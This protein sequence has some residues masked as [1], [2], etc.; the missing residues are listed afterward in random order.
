MNNT[1]CLTSGGHAA[2]AKQHFS[3]KPLRPRFRSGRISASP[4]LILFGVLVAVLS[5]ALARV[6][7]Q[8]AE[9]AGFSILEDNAGRID[10]FVIQIAEGE[11]VRLLPTI[12]DLLTQV[13][14]RTEGFL[15]CAA[16]DEANEL[17]MALNRWNLAQPDRF[18]ILVLPDVATI[19]ARDRFVAVRR[20]TGESTL[21]LPPVREPAGGDFWVPQLLARAIPGLAVRPLGF[22]AEG[23][24][25]IAG[26]DRLFVGA[27]NV[28]FAQEEFQ[29]CTESELRTL[30][31]RQFGKPVV[32]LPD[33][34]DDDEEEPT[35]LDYHLDMFL[36]VC[37]DDS[38]V[39]AD[40]EWGERLA[41][42]KLHFEQEL[43]LNQE[44]LEAIREDLAFKRH[45]LDAVYACLVR[46][47][48]R[49]HRIPLLWI[50]EADCGMTYN[51]VLQEDS[52]NGPIVYLPQ[53]GINE[54]DMAAA[55]VYSNLG[56][57]VR[58]VDV[59][60]VFELQG[61]LRCVVNVIR[62]E[63]MLKWE[64]GDVQVRRNPTAARRSAIVLAKTRRP[65]HFLWPADS[66]LQA[67]LS[68]GHRGEARNPS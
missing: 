49:V 41:G 18:Q 3:Q 38:V 58:P 33:F 10:Q 6:P 59:R 4:G 43:P 11:L 62:R 30:L 46:A 14:S 48:I 45:R 1:F 22:Y 20:P 23:G 65:N 25:L 55:D 42:G 53:Y 27:T 16:Q 24:D 40:L 8:A 54:I 56:Y 39:L 44:D 5:A 9:T 12:H 15:V 28:G 26:H 63:P 64:N 17:Q 68:R 31:E 50:P 47:G 19:W 2:W 57:E 51:N 32:F 13:D 52:P 29:H 67:P 66:P 21:L 36:T 35:D 61:T 60:Q 7:V 34:A 37:H